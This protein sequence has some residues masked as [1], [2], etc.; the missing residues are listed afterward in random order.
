M[1]FNV[2]G[3]LL[4]K[5]FVEDFVRTN[6]ITPKNQDEYKGAYTMWG[7]PPE[8]LFT[9]YTFDNNFEAGSMPFFRRND[10]LLWRKAVMD[11]GCIYTQRWGD[12]PLRFMTMAIF[13]APEEVIHR[14]SLNIRYCHPA[15]CS[16]PK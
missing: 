16:T 9:M 4:F 2:P 13:A 6:A 14:R 1:P 7:R 5:K 10:L 8:Q 15:P 12:A 3:A 11:T